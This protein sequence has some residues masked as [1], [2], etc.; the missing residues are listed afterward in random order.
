[1]QTAYNGGIII[2]SLGVRKLSLRETEKKKKSNKLSKITQL[3]NA[4]LGVRPNPAQL[5]CSS[6][7]FLSDHLLLPEGSIILILWLEAALGRFE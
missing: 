6:D 3:M 5:L 4:E 2:S 7:P 1:M